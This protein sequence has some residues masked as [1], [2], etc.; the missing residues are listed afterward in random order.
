MVQP[1]ATP[2]LVPPGNLYRHTLLDPDQFQSLVIFTV[3]PGTDSCD[4]LQLL[5]VVGTRPLR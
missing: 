1:R 4:K 5:S 3:V 2:P